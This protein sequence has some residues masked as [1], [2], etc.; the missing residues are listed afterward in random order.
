MKSLLLILCLG[1][2]GCEPPDPNVSSGE[3]TYNLGAGE[4]IRIKTI[5]IEGNEYYATDTG[6]DG[7]NWVLCPKL[8]PKPELAGPARPEAP[9]K[10]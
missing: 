4:K 6:G 2:C 1:L 5:L 10:P 9:I 7:S 8:P 3:V